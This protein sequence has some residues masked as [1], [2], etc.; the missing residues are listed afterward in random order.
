MSNTVAP[1]VQPGLIRGIRR[2]DFVALI[3]NITIGAGILGLPSKIYN[4]VGAY[5]LVAY[6]VSA[7]VVTLI[8]LC[9]AEV[10]S[11]FSGTGGPYLYAREAFGPLVGFEVGWLLWV[12]RLA[13]FASICNLLVSYAA[14]F[15]PAVEHG[16]PR[17][18]VITGL[19]GTLTAINLIGVHTAS[20]VNNLFTVSKLLVLLLFTGVGLFFVDFD[21]YSFATPPTYANFS[22]AAMLLIFTFSGFDVAAIPSGE[23][24]DP[25]RTIPF[26]L[27]TAI[28]TVALLFWLVQAVCIG[29][30]PGLAASERPLAD[31]SQRFLGPAGG[32][33]IAVAALLT[34]LGTLN[35]LMLTGPR[36]LFALAEQKQVPAWL[37]A[38]H[39]RFRTP[40]VALLISAVLKLVLAITGT[41][42]YALTLSTI[43]RLF[44]FGLTCAALPVLRRRQP[45][46][47]AP[48]HLRG[49]WVVA[50]LSVL[51]CGWLLSNSKGD[52]ARD[53]LIAAA[54]GLVLYF[55][56]RRGSRAASSNK[57]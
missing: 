23:V 37:G 31:A 27:F 18:L 32:A 55:F 49:G 4:L 6:G 56:S 11:R 39:P 48:F 43:I 45:Q 28:A 13:S 57:P 16:W 19:I 33:F 50:G 20:L 51:L 1:A 29:T 3:I 34:A 24:K 10:S 14:Y 21:A 47:P 40:H 38:T 2:W 8:I 52:E 7:A 54:V 46:V 12:S 26:G 42:I 41:F 30:L 22:M 36:L 44:Y 17:A 15:W 53:V 25:Q 9:F 5:S 35:A